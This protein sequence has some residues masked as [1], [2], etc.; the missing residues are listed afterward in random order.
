MKFRIKVSFEEK[1]LP[2]DPVV[3]QKPEAQRI[4]ETPTINAY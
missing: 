3:L 4:T 1:D 2:Y